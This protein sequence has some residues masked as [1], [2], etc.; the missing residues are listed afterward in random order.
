MSV[1]IPFVIWGYVNFPNEA[2]YVRLYDKD[3]NYIIFNVVGISG[4]PGYV[5]N[6]GNLFN[7][8]VENE[9]YTLKEYNASNVE[10][11]SQK[12]VLSTS[13]YK[14]PFEAVDL[15]VLN[16]DFL[17]TPNI[18]V[19][20][21]AV[22]ETPSEI[23]ISENSG[24][25]GYNWQPYREITP[26]T[27]SLSEGSHT[28]YAK[29]RDIT[30]TE[31]RIPNTEIVLQDATPGNPQ[32]TVKEG[33]I[34]QSTDIH[35]L[36]RVDYSYEMMVSANSSFVDAVW[37]PFQQEIPFTVEPGVGLKIIY[38]KFRNVFRR[39]SNVVFTKTF[40]I[41]EVGTPSE[42]ELVSPINIVEG[43]ITYTPIVSNMTLFE[44]KN[45]AEDGVLKYRLELST[46]NFE[47]IEEPYYHESIYA[48]FDQ[49]TGENYFDKQF[50]SDPWRPRLDDWTWDDGEGKLV[51]LPSKAKS[52]EKSESVLI[53]EDF[54]DINIVLGQA[55]QEDDHETVK[56]FYTGIYLNDLNYENIDKEL[57]VFDAWLASF[58]KPRVLD[59]II[60]WDTLNNTYNLF[61]ER[62]NTYTEDYRLNVSFVVYIKNLTEYTTETGFN[63]AVEILNK[64]VTLFEGYGFKI[65][66]YTEKAFAE[67]CVSFNNNYLLYLNNRGHEIGT[68]IEF[69][70]NMI[71]QDEKI[72]YVIIRKNAIDK[73]G[74]KDNVGITGGWDMEDWVE[75]YPSMQYLW[76]FNY[77]IP[78]GY[79]FDD[80]EW[81]L[82]RTGYP[83][84]ATCQF[85]I[86]FIM[87]LPPQ[88]YQWRVKAYN[89]FAWGI[90]SHI[91]NFKVGKYTERTVEWYFKVKQDRVK[92]YW[93]NGL[94]ITE[95]NIMYIKGEM[96]VSPFEHPITISGKTYPCQVDGEWWMFV[97]KKTDSNYLTMAT[98]CVGFGD[99]YQYPYI[100]SANDGWI[101]VLYF[102]DGVRARTPAAG[103]NYV[104]VMADNLPIRDYI[105]PED[106]FLRD[107]TNDEK[108]HGA[109]VEILDLPAHVTKTV[110]VSSSLKYM[111]TLIAISE[112]NRRAAGV[113]TQGWG[114][115][116]IGV[117]DMV[118]ISDVNLAG[119]GAFAKGDNYDVCLKNGTITSLSGQVRFGKN[120]RP[121]RVKIISR[122]R[123]GLMV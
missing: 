59:D 104:S 28:I 63:K 42:T 108:I 113:K 8:W 9:S 21:G 122:D 30:G 6:V 115:G 72:N 25:S 93:T 5:I 99:K 68:Y 44:F 52:I 116:L 90:Y 97:K 38:A 14:V 110:F 89:G 61:I 107:H 51:Y 16:S 81:W 123:P 94:I 101:P 88:E 27:V 20:F 19:E 103:S 50:T 78:E 112:N 23:T 11:C 70:T 67:G 45:K 74:V 106:K 17:Y 37:L 53:Y 29:V 46:N 18:E 100:I 36:L 95:D 15:S 7:Q 47:I 41:S 118:D 76:A 56:S 71:D 48:V 58:I 102:Q 22:P 65:C 26:F 109:N 32:I 4:R 111:M 35:L 117:D 83:G 96:G 73:L 121:T 77:G 66:I 57:D 33:S 43:S 85:K 87:E 69:P 82:S 80:D 114:I 86:P 12:I 62:N 3:G 39:E 98:G 120:N 34:I 54:S 40:L 91:G 60:R 119:T 79:R 64:L 13:P 2:S 92:V 84:G 105:H 75:L 24:F 55:V 49:V 31:S 10:L 1:H